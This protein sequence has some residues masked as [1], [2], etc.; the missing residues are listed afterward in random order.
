MHVCKPALKIESQQLLRL[1]DSCDSPMRTKRIVN[2]VLKNII[3]INKERVSMAKVKELTINDIE[4]LIEQ[5]LL[6][7]F[8]QPIP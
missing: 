2:Q 3:D 6:E 8:G 5:K 1:S 7:I 4:Q